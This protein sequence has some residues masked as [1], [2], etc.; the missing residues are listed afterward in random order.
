[1]TA[2][3]AAPADHAALATD[4]RARV[5]T[6]L[7]QFLSEQAAVLGGIGP[8]L[9]PVTE[10]LQEFLLEGGKRLRPTFAY[11]GYRGAGGE[12]STG[13]VTAAASLELLHACALIHD[14][15]MDGSDTRRGH[16]AVHRRFS[17]LHGKQDWEGSSDAFGES[18]AILLG[19][20]CL[21]WAEQMLTTCGLPAEAVARVRPVYDEMRVELMSGQYL[22]LLEQALGGHDMARVLRVA[23]F[24]SAKYTIER[25]LH[26]GAALAGGDP[27]VRDAYSAYGLPLGEAFQLRDDV[28]GVFGDPELTGKPA[29]DDLR[30]GKR[31]ALIAMAL[32]QA[33]D[34]QAAVVARHLGDPDLDRAGVEALRTVIAD[35]GALGRV[36]V[37]IEQ[38]T[39]QAIAALRPSLA[40]AG[41]GPVD[42]EAASVLQ[43]LA[44][45][46]TAR[47]V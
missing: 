34:A 12:D 28:L 32:E 7:A 39:E 29:G 40:G 10:A 21:V 41:T 45:A 38:R 44:V 15:V 43:Q 23:R 18:A 5:Q 27:A 46:A 47:R 17:M 19:D 20:L 22:D 30:E 4:L 37:L 24:K 25:P 2:G 16:P 42:S 1:M 3:P 11:W 33:D 14:D 8:D 9:D 13:I 36:E 6:V 26:V 35:T 31:T